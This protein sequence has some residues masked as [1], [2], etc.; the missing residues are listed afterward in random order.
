MEGWT[1][2]RFSD[3]VEI[4]PA[5]RLQSSK[6]YSFVEMKDLSESNKFATP[7][8][9]RVLSG[10]ARFENADTLFARI[11][12]CLE[13]GKICQVKDLENGVGF[14]STEFL[15]FRGKKDVSISEFVFYLS[16]YDEVRKFGEKN[17]SGTSGRQRV[18]REAFNN[19]YLKLPPFEEQ[20]GIAKILSS[21]DDKIELNRRMNATLEAMA[22]ALF[23]AWFV[24][25]EPVHANLE[26]RPSTSASPEIAKLFPSNFENGIPKGWE[27]KS[28]HQVFEINPLRSLTKGAIA[29]YLDMASSP[30]SG[31]R[32]SAVVD[33]E[34]SSG[35]RFKNG[36]TLLARITPCL[37]NGKTAFVDFLN[38]Q[39]IGWGSTEFIVLRSKKGLPEYF[40]YLLCRNEDFRNFAIQS[41]TGTSGRQ[42]V[43]IDSLAKY[44]LSV[45]PLDSSIGEQFGSLLNPLVAKIKQNSEEIVCL[46]QIRNSLL[47]KLISGQIRMQYETYAL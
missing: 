21:L 38:D 47:P 46:A 32:V 28:L 8:A 22:R 30:T 16:R 29:K 5:V 19:L 15:V 40:A 11:T 10:G 43:Q 34:F 14:G 6:E 31:H 36:D 12:P 33:R 17:M 45:P 23:K 2:Y 42:R 39:E 35:M 27:E 24:D 18:N 20:R 4:N 13:N 1:T 3:F 44:S 7:S 41:M 25:F 26:T 37:E 9:K